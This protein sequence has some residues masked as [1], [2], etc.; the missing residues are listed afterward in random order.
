MRDRAVSKASRKKSRSFVRRYEKRKKRRNGGER[1]SAARSNESSSLFPFCASSN[2]S[3]PCLLYPVNYGLRIY[4]TLIQIVAGYISDN[5]YV[6]RIGSQ[7]PI[8]SPFW[9][10]RIDLLPQSSPEKEIISRIF[11]FWF[12][13]VSTWFS[14]CILSLKIF[15]RTNLF[16][17]FLFHLCKICCLILIYYCILFYPIIAR[18]EK[19]FTRKVKRCCSDYL[20]TS[21]MRGYIKIK[22]KSIFFNHSI[23]RYF[24]IFCMKSNPKN[25]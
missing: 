6:D 9:L 21:F 12:Y 22:W 10:Y 20:I 16:L 4:C 11:F 13:S 5:D 25:Y 24:N 2:A 7:R 17:G 3:L 19:Y 14:T 23:F 1:R 15:H 8:F 18:S